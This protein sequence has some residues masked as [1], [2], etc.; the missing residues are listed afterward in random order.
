MQ[1]GLFPAVSAFRHV[2]RLCATFRRI[3]IRQ[4]A[5]TQRFWVAFLAFACRLRGISAIRLRLRVQ[6]RPDRGVLFVPPIG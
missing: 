4:M 3:A 2:P 6:K 1:F 5:E